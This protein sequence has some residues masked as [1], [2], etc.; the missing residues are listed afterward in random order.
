M[1]GFN[2]PPAPTSNQGENIFLTS[3]FY[4]ANAYPGSGTNSYTPDADSNSTADYEELPT[5]IAEANPAIISLYADLV[6]CQPA[7]GGI[8]IVNHPGSGG[9]VDGVSSGAIAGT[10]VAFLDGHDAWVK[11][12]TVTTGGSSNEQMNHFTQGVSD[13]YWWK[14]S[15]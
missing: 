13:S 10:N 14:T 8:W 1:W 3:Y 2:L 12:N 9:P 15:H 6:M 5:S 7:A 11:I 4:L